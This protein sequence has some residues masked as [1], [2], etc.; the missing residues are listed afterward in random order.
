MMFHIII[1]PIRRS[2]GLPFI[3]HIQDVVPD[4]IVTV[5]RDEDVHDGHLFYTI[6]II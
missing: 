1:F 4:A 6:G 5:M 2:F 3:N